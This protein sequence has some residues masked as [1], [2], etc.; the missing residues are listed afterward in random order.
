M[1]LLNRY[2]R[3]PLEAAMYCITW[4]HASWYFSLGL[5][6]IPTTDSTVVYRIESSSQTVQTPHH[7]SRKSTIA[8]LVEE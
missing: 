7:R 8:L 4:V 5:S 1:N 2:S 3:R 6:F